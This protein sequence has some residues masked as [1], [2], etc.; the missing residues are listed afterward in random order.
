M[1]EHM[2]G[3]KFNLIQMTVT[4]YSIENTEES[5]FETLDDVLEHAKVHGTW[6]AVRQ[7]R[8]V[9]YAVHDPVTGD[10]KEQEH[11]TQE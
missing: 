6:G 9:R 7:E 11:S 5:N 10:Y 8:S 1:I 3:R 2:A 4:T